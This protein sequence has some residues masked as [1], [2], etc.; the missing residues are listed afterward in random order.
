MN[1]KNTT[2][3]T[4]LLPKLCI[5]SQYKHQNAVSHNRAP[6]RPRLCRGISK[7]TFSRRAYRPLFIGASSMC[8]QLRASLQ[9]VRDMPP[10]RPLCCQFNVFLYRASTETI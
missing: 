2:H 10:T 4:K 5:P 7:S 6:L 9:R 8:I 3:K 1:L